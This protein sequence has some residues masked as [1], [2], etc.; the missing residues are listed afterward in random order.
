MTQL[1]HPTMPRAAV[2]RPFGPYLLL[3]LAC[4]FWGGNVV[5]GRAL[6]MAG[7]DQ[8]SPAVLNALRWKTC[9]V[10]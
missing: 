4:A 10:P 3:I 2:S 5:A 8:I 6:A 1:A 7:P 9:L